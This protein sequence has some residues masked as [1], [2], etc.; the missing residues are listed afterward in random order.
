MFERFKRLQSDDLIT[1]LLI[2]AL[3]TITK[4]S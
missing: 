3:K 1:P 2:Y 4:I